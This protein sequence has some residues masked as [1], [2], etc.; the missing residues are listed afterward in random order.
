MTG[1]LE[2]QA[3]TVTGAGSGIGRATTKRL[4]ADGAD[5][6]AVDLNGVGL[7]ETADLVSGEPGRCVTL[8]GNITEDDAPTAIISAGVEA[9]GGVR[10]LVDSAGTGG[11][12][13]TH[14]TVDDD[15]DR[16]LDVNLHALFRM[17]RGAVTA[18]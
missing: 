16:F 4:M 9:F 12:M 6:L 5:V 14:M 17:A 10:I 2:G 13:A 7:A 8:A 1:R 15:L 3:A 18:I 11:A